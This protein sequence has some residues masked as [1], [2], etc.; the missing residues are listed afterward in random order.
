MASLLIDF[1]NIVKP[2]KLALLESRVQPIPE[3]MSKS[4]FSVSN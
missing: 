2:N 4:W 3:T 1:D